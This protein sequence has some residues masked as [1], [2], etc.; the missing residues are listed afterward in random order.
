MEKF[1]MSSPALLSQFPDSLHV[2]DDD[3]TH[4]SPY[5]D[6]DFAEFPDFYDGGINLD[7]GPK[8]FDNSLQAAFSSASDDRPATAP[9]AHALQALSHP[10][11]AQH[12]PFASFP[13][14]PPQTSATATQASPFLHL[15]NVSLDDYR[16]HRH[17]HLTVSV[18]AEPPL[19]TFTHSYSSTTLHL[20]ELVPQLLL[21]ISNPL[22]LDLPYSGVAAT[23]G[24]RQKLASI[25]SHNF[26][27]PLRG[28]SPGPKIGKTPHLAKLHR[29]TRLRVDG[30]SNLLATIA[31]MKLS[32]SGN[33]ASMNPFE[34][35]FA[36]PN[37]RELSDYEAT[38][39][40]TPA[41]QLYITPVS[42]NHSF[43]GSLDFLTLSS[44]L[45]SLGSR[46]NDT[47]DSIHFEDQ[48][49]DA[50]KQLRKAKSFTT[51][52]AKMMRPYRQDEDPRANFKKLTSI[53]LLLA[54]LMAKDRRLR[55]YPASMDLVSITN[56]D[57]AHLDLSMSAGSS[58][59]TAG[60]PMSHPQQQ[61]LLPPMGAKTPRKRKSISK[62]ISLGSYPTPS[63]IQEA[64]ATEEIA[65]FAESILNSDLKRPIVVKALLTE[66]DDPKK[67]HKCPLCLARFQRPEHVKRHLKSH[68]T[69]KPFQCD[70][71]ECGRRFNRKDNLKAHLKK[72]HG[73]TDLSMHQ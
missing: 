37:M 63:Q 18:L 73:L 25:S 52:D 72:I 7:L 41:K 29:R 4:K 10:Q 20:G 44:L 43:G 70:L 22:L 53:D 3:D 47:L 33:N 16:G 1:L 69:E 24:R 23:P 35:A 67:K 66:L 49:D 19:G 36:L 8:H 5:D 51:F 39:L 6:M 2:M 32:S 21:L 45:A 65:K 27:T 56:T 42:Q 48:D 57:L 31:N 26:T 61:G 64:S 38:P 12:A 50:C 34:G 71:P 9:L 17:L 59:G 62:P 60:V 40:A 30:S 54:E 11:H 68:S 46:R 55:S 14:F 28:H 15:R 58:N 13:H